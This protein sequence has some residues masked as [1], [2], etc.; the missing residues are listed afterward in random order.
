MGRLV[1]QMVE[2]G[3]H[4]VDELAAAQIACIQASREQAKQIACLLDRLVPIGGGCGRQQILESDLS[5][6]QCF[7][8]GLDLGSQTS[9]VGCLLGC[10]AAMS[11]EIGRLIGHNLFLRVRHLRILRWVNHL[12]AL[13]QQAHERLGQ[14]L[15]LSNGLRHHAV[16]LVCSKCPADV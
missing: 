13:V 2:V 3:Q 7:L 12:S 10:H 11:I 16:P 4:P 5:C 14:A 9:K 15:I 6:A 1:E 8:I